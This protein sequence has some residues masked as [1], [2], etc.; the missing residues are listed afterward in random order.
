MSANRKNLHSHLTEEDVLA[1]TDLVDASSHFQLESKIVI[2]SNRHAPGPPATEFFTAEIYLIDPDGGN[3]QRLTNNTYADT[4]PMLSPDGKHIVFD[5]NRL[6]ANSNTFDLFVM[7]ADGSDQMWLTRGDS[8]TWSP[9]SKNIIFHASDLYYDRNGTET[10]APTRPDPGAA[11]VDSDLFLANVDDLAAAP[12]LLSKIQ[13]VTNIT[14]TPLLIEDDADWSEA[15]GLIVFTSRPAPGTE[16]DFINT[17]IYVMDPLHPELGRQQL[18]FDNG[19]EE[20]SPSWSPDGTQIAFSAR[21]G[22]NDNEICVMNIADGIIHQLTDN[23]IADLGP[24]WS[25]DGTQI[26]F[27]RTV[28]GRP[29]VFTMNPELNPDGTLPDAIPVTDFGKGEGTNRFPQWGEVRTKVDSAVPGDG[30][31]E[32]FFAGS[33]ADD[34]IQTLVKMAKFEG[35]VSE[36]IQDVFLFNNAGQMGTERADDVTPGG[37]RDLGQFGQA[38]SD[39]VAQLNSDD[40]PFPGQP[41][42]GEWLQ[43][44]FFV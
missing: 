8:P 33:Q 5:S 11:A 20:R 3:P 37:E 23:T 10:G 17:E 31:N 1:P 27:Q 7:D 25:P 42:Y 36:H 4:F 29:Q 34:S 18:T 12:D 28:A 16:A 22:G 43:E 21:I 14:N 24:S 30:A 13:L 39:F 44:F 19:Y 38:Q 9:D 41:H 40:N 35:T 26:A 32:T 6:T 2:T 15:N